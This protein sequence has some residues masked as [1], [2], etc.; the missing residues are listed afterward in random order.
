MPVPS[1]A[2]AASRSD[3]LDVLEDDIGAHRLQ[4]DVDL[5]TRMVAGDHAVELVATL[6][7]ER[8]DKELLGD[9]RAIGW[10]HTGVRAAVVQFLVDPLD[11]VGDRGHLP[12]VRKGAQ[13]L[14][15]PLDAL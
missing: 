5:R 1:N 2:W 7:A 9:R 15:Q 6:A 8:E 4:L 11:V 10:D 12:N 3:V 14:L 13:L